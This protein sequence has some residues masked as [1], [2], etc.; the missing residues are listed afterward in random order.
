VLGKMRVGVRIVS[1]QLEHPICCLFSLHPVTTL[2]L[3]MKDRRGWVGLVPL[4]PLSP[5]DPRT[6]DEVRLIKIAAFSHPIPVTTLGLLM[7]GRLDKY[8]LPI[9]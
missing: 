4:L 8:S 1:F 2:V 3:L 6:T 7:I 5:D 9:P